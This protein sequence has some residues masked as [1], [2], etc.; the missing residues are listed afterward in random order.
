MIVCDAAA[1]AAR[2]PYAALVEA[3]AG[4]LRAKTAGTAQAPERLVV[5]LRPQDPRGGSLLCMPAADDD[6]AV[7]KLI[8]VHAANRAAGLP[9]IQGEMTVM[10]ARTGMRLLLLDGAVV[11]A[12]RTAAASVLAVRTLAAWPRGPLLV[13]GAG[14]QA[15]AHVAAFREMLGV[16]RVFVHARSA[17][18][19]EALA[20]QAR[21]LGMTA[22]TVADPAAVLDRCPLVVTATT[23]PVPVLP[24]APGQM[25]DGTCIVAVGSFHA[26]QAEIP[27]SLMRRAR[28]V[29]DSL[30]AARHEAGDVLLAGLDW[31]RIAALET[32]LDAPPTPRTPGLVVYKSVGCAYFDLAAGRVAAAAS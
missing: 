11:T 13:V 21:S 7:T 10:D 28:V 22:E 2:L 27:A 17:A 4:V 23:S 29:V 15:A 1:T 19:A 16:E 3:V 32:L 6:V 14:V 8:T 12:R 25:R 20:D 9:V 18:S 31:A 5:R 26:D 30:E 24:D